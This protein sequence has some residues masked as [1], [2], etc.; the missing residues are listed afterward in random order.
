MSK[1]S[2]AGRRERQHWTEWAVAWAVTAMFVLICGAVSLRHEDWR[3]E[4]DAWLIA[5]D[6][7][8][9]EVWALTRKVGMPATWYLL[10]MPA[11][12]AGL[13]PIWMHWVN[14]AA[15]V[16]AALIM[17]R[18]GPFPWL[19][20]ASIVF[21][22]MF[23]YE[24]AIVARPYSLVALG[25]FAVAALH[26]GHRR[27]PLALGLAVAFLANTT[28]HG[29]FIAFAYATWF[30][31]DA[32]RGRPLDRRTIVALVVMAAGGA[33]C[34]AQLY[35]PHPAQFS[36]AAGIR[37]PY[38]LE[39]AL[40]NLG[41]IPPPEMEQ[42]G[43]EPAL[44]INSLLVALVVLVIVRQRSAAGG[45]TL[46]VGIVL[47]GYVFLY[48][49]FQAPRHAGMVTVLLIMSTWIA[50]A[51]DP[52]MRRGRFARQALHWALG[53]A[54]G[55]SVTTA[56]SWWL[57]D[58]R[59]EYSHGRQMARWIDAHYPPESGI[60]ISSQ[61]YGTSVLM[62]SHR[63][64][65]W[66][67]DLRQWGSYCPWDANYVKNLGLHPRIMMARTLA[68]F[69]DRNVRLLLPYGAGFRFDGWELEHQTEGTDG[70]AAERAQEA[71]F[72]Y[73]PSKP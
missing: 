69:G 10:N 71:F 34:V 6:A 54:M 61:I 25:A 13:N 23:A 55:I 47:L 30:A 8:V 12:K 63:R 43:T 41:A 31:F 38:A 22:Y 52:M 35:D 26:R 66:Y 5:R 59:Y 2:R 29:L 49:W 46:L 14:L 39:D 20:R 24:Y 51:D 62:Y 57:W 72:L 53:V 7:G 50:V 36:D 1:E 21:S 3:D 48:K 17:L 60:V 64:Q 32:V 65:F 56:V 9:S 37:Y 73:R 19:V 27:H 16:A 44:I 70:L 28:V 4:A 67:A 40:R 18:W 11:A 42:F 68:Q 15:A 45:W 58:W 33:L